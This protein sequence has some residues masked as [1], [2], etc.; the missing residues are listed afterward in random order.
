MFIEE[1]K[2]IFNTKDEY[3]ISNKGRI[4]YKG[5]FIYPVLKNNYLCIKFRNVWEPIHEL[6]AFHFIVNTDPL[7]HT[8]IYHIDQN[9]LNNQITNLKWVHKR[10]FVDVP[11]HYIRE[12]KHKRKNKTYIYY[13][14]Y[15]DGG[16]LNRCK[17]LDQATRYL[18]KYVEDYKTYKC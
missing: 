1:W 8:M 2:P 6:V 16:L 4:K 9:T 3:S 13:N 15:F 10:E 18:E 7:E 12:V 5:E 14:V 17:C 11:S